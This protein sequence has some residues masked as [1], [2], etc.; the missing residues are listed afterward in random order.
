MN[1]NQNDQVQFRY[2]INSLTEIDSI[3]WNLLLAAG[4]TDMHE[5][6]N[7]NTTTF[8]LV[9]RTVLVSLQA[10]IPTF[11]NKFKISVLYTSYFVQKHL[12]NVLDVFGAW[13]DQKKKHVPPSLNN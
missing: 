1:K 7:L 9:S 8:L 12:H 3:I 13:E 6:I 4:Q 5:L 11:T 2:N 10:A